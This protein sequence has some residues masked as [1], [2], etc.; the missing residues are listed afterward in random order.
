M[1]KIKD[2]KDAAKTAAPKDA[3]ETKKTSAGPKDEAEKE[4]AEENGEAE[5]VETENAEA[6]KVEAEA[7]EASSKKKKD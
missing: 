1:A 6:E 3:E 2:I 4:A 7:S 5:N